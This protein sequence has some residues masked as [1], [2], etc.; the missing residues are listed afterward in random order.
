M[1]VRPIVMAHLDE[2][3][4]R[5]R[6]RRVPDRGIDRNIRRLAEDLQETVLEHHGAGLAAPQIGELWRVCVVLDDEGRVVPMINPEIVRH[7]GAILDFEG[8]LS[9]PG[10]WG[11]VER[12]ATVTVK[13]LDVDGHPRRLK[14]SQ[15]VARAVQHEID[16]LDGVLFVDRM[17]EPGKLYRLDYDEQDEPIYIPL[18]EPEHEPGAVSASGQRHIA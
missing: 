1:A 6:S 18:N 5:R 16:H 10:L 7:N 4:L 8:C 3:T 9:F 12:F 13:F 2:A 15:I 11:K 14:V 17:A